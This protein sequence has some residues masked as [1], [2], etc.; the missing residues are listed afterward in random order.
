MPGLAANDAA[1]GHDGVIGPAGLLGRI[2]RDGDGGR[3]FERAVEGQHVHDGLRL[4]DGA[5]RPAQKLVGD[6]VVEA[7]LD[8]QDAG[9][10]NR[11]TGAFRLIGRR[12]HETSVQSS[13]N[14]PWP[15]PEE[16]RSTVS[17]EDPESA[18]DALVLRDAAFSGS[19][20]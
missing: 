18:G 8:D 6:V 3:D 7:G 1:E 19:S 17:K 12:D 4:L 16:V 11:R 13:N 2:E 9:A 10:G 14:A 5:F 20:G 15:H